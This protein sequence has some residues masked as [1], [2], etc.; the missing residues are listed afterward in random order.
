MSR[1]LLSLV[2]AASIIFGGAAIAQDTNLAAPL[3]PCEAGSQGLCVMRATR[4]ADIVGVW[5]GS[6]GNPAL[7]AS[8]GVAYVRYNADGTYALADTIV[9]TASPHPPYPSGTVVFQGIIMTIAEVPAPIGSPECASGSYVASVYR[10]GDTPVALLYTPIKDDC[11]GRKAGF[12]R[13]Q[14]W[15]AEGVGTAT[16][17][18]VQHTTGH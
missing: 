13:P 4:S 2:V 5:K 8:G 6:L 16:S 3:V 7:P 10:F 17:A 11:A 9:N 12:M 14:M 18:Q 1:S 15:V